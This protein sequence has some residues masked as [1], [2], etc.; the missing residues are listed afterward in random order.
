[1]ETLTLTK[2]T[3][4]QNGFFDLRN[5]IDKFVKDN[6]DVLYAG[7]IRLNCAIPSDDFAPKRVQINSTRLHEKLGL[8]YADGHKYSHD[9]AP[10]KGQLMQTIKDLQALIDVASEKIPAPFIL[11][12]IENEKQD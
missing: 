9:T 3:I 11:N 2:K 7:A 6:F 1:M 10:S 4:G 12:I 5:Q 8:K